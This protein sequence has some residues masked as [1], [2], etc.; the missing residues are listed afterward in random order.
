[1][2]PALA[3]GA[4]L[5]VP[6]PETR[7]APA[8][9][10]GWFARERV[11][12]TWTPTP[13]AEALLAEPAPPGL[14][15]RYLQTGGDRLHRRAPA[16]A[17]YRLNNHY[18]PVENA[19]L[20]TEGDIPPEGAPAGPGAS[21]LPTIGRPLDGV[22]IH[23]L[24]RSLAL[25]PW[26]APGEL[27]LGGRGVARGYLGDPAQT[28]ERFLP[29]PY[30]GV[31]GSRMYRT[32]DLVCFRP[33]GE[34]DFLGRLDTQV[35][36]RGQRIELGEIEAALAELPG[37]REAA[38]LAR[39]ESPGAAGK[40]LVAYVVLEPGAEVED[41]DLVEPLA[42]RLT[43]AMV[44]RAFVFLER[45]PATANGKVDRRALAAIAPAAP[46]VGETEPR[47]ETE[48]LVAAV[49]AEV[50]GLERVGVE[51]DFFDLGGHSLLAAKLTWRL[52]EELGVEVPVALLF[53]APT[54]AGLAE[55]LADLPPSQA[56]QDTAEPIQRADRSAPLP[57]SF[58]QERLWFLE[59]L[60]GPSPLYHI[61]AAFDGTGRLE[62]E[63]LRA[64][65]A[66]LWSRH[67]ALRA[68][69]LIDDG[70]PFQT[71]APPGAPP[72]LDVDLAVA[73]GEL[74]RLTGEIVRRPF[75]L[76]R[77]PLLRVVVLRTGAESFRLVLVI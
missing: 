49:W 3:V 45:L 56:S 10:L 64:A 9:L 75:D 55:R 25:A 57:L 20:S 7:L 36:I 29:D 48:A 34:I 72:V 15:L 33:D 2:W 21:S 54:V 39:Q 69:F 5:H 43:E 60:E 41:R 16:G 35:K 44:P 74:D 14:A 26:G 62:V 77:D 70:F 1:I 32:G 24:D 11:T 47:T 76:E 30:S 27:F 42:R 37:V 22:R 38:V 67:E 18:G 66:A 73:A 51:D 13:I 63:A 61:A 40:R 53:E 4:S 8:A 6:P 58:S 65:V 50:L 28:A 52:R 23:L 31:P 17:A 19:V 59:Q 68:R 71:F 46:E 12:V